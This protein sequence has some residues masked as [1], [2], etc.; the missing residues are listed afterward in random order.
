M[1]NFAIILVMSSLMKIKLY[2]NITLRKKLNIP[3]IVEQYSNTPSQYIILSFNSGVYTYYNCWLAWQ[4]S[5]LLLPCSNPM[6]ESIIV[7][8]GL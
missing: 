2:T 1:S 5:N 4:E 3:S 8:G 6:Y 7:F